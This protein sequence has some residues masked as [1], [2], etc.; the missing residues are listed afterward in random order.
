LAGG[1]RVTAILLV[2]WWHPAEYQPVTVSR[3]AKKYQHFYV[4][5]SIFDLFYSEGMNLPLDMTIV[6]VNLVAATYESPQC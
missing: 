5:V 1:T 4:L 3:R 2:H 6:M